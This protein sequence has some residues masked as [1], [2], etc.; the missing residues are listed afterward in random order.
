MTFDF[1]RLPVLPATNTH[2]ILID[3]SLINIEVIR[4]GAQQF[5][6]SDKR[7]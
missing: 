6:D 2:R 1:Q 5:F 7:P 3:S 4:I